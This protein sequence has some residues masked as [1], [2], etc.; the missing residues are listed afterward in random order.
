MELKESHVILHLKFITGA[1][2]NSSKFIFWHKKVED[3][4]TQYKGN[5]ISRN[6]N[7]LSMDL[8]HRR[9]PADLLVH[10]CCLSFFLSKQQKIR[11]DFD[12]S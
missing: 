7:I 10:R 4:L 9:S 11:Y 1:M 3:E 6:N 12:D 2:L 8:G 5:E